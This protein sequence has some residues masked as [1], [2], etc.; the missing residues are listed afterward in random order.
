MN[1]TQRVLLFHGLI[2]Q[3]QAYSYDCAIN[4]VNKKI[5]NKESFVVEEVLK[6]EKI[7]SV[8]VK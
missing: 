2:T 5:K 3:E 4:E 8:N 6:S 7:K 1:E